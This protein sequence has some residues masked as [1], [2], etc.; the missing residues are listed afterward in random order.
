MRGA[1]VAAAIAAFAA[2]VPMASAQPAPPS[3]MPAEPPSGLTGPM[4]FTVH[5]GVPEWIGIGFGHAF[6]GER[7]RAHLDLGTMLFVSS[8]TAHV[9]GMLVRGDGIALVTGVH[10]G[11]MWDHDL[12]GE[13]P[14]PKR[15][16]DVGARLGIEIGNPRGTG[17]VIEG[18]YMFQTLESLNDGKRYTPSLALRVIRGWQ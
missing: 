3:T 15:G 10:A 12:I 17:F 11:V 18:G 4:Y 2:S 9:Q 14:Q 16:F 8:L 7:F 13:H 5:F 1:R 6:A